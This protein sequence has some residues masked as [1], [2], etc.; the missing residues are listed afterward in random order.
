MKKL[1]IA[2]AS[3]ALLAVA[4]YFAARTILP[5]LWKAVGSGKSP[6]N[7]IGTVLKKEHIRGTE[8]QSTGTLNLEQFVVYYRLD[9][10]HDI[11]AAEREAVLKAEQFRFAKEGQRKM[12]VGRKDYEALVE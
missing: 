7:A 11:A 1:A 12:E 3:V 6:R 9:E 8:D 4:L 2:V 10:F 5:A